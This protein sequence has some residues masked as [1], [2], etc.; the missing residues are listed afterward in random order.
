LAALPRLV[1]ICDW[2]QG[3]SWLF[4]ALERLSPLGPAVAVQHRHPE[5]AGR[6]FLEEARLLAALCARTGMPLFVN[7]RLDVALLV[8]AHLHLPAHGPSPDDVRPHLPR[9]RWVSAAV[10]DEAEAA[11]ATGA[12][13]ALVSPVFGAGSKPGDARPP[14]GPAGFCRLRA[15]L[16]CPAYALGGVSAERAQAIRGQADGLAVVTAVLGAADPLTAAGAL[17]DIV[18]PA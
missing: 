12:A 18:R 16:S 6:Q 7:G 3:A 9:G 1:V 2:A 4:G 14:L 8:E 10:H 11:R 17:L 5:A 13:L 15:A